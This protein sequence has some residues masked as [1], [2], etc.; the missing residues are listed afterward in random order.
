ME[1]EGWEIVKCY[2]SDNLAW[3]S[4]DEKQ[5]SGDHRL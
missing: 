2:S 3:N 5:L 4:D 1:K